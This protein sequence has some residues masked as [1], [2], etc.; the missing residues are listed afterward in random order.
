M[1]LH[2]PLTSVKSLRLKPNKARDEI[3]VLKLRDVT[4]HM[5]SRSVTCHPTQ[6]SAPR[7]NPNQ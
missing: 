1:S 2:L 6:V 7:F 4:R 5:E 3:P